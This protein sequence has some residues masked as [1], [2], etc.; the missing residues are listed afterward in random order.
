M[1]KKVKKSSGMLEDKRDGWKALVLLAPALLI[2]IVF[3]IFPIVNSFIISFNADFRFVMNGGVFAIGHFKPGDNIGFGAYINV[4]SDPVFQKALLNTLIIVVVSVPLTV[5]LGLFIAVGLNGINKLKGFFQTIFFLPYVTN[6]IAL[7]MVFKVMFASPEYN[8]VI[9]FIFNTGINF[10]GDASG[11][12]DETTVRWWS[13][14]VIVIYTVWNGLAF[15]ILIFMSGLQGIDKQYYDAAR[16]D[17]ASKRRIFSKIT[18]PLLSPMIAYVTIT[19]FIGAFKSYSSIIAI[20]Q[21]GADKFGPTGADDMWITVAGYIY[22][23]IPGYLRTG[24]L[25]KAAAGSIVLLIIILFITCI[26]NWV[27]KKRV[28]F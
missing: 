25:A 6:T 12:I 23:Y 19:S 3:M 17:G 21:R 27:N 16:I 26:Q 9:N 11:A 15:K 28:H 22:R 20:F 7:G 13:F 24:D 8:G 4:L 5:L 10:L 14:L 18:V 1:A 2:L